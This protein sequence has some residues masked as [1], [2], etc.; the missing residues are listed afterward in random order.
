[1]DL[2]LS[3]FN[4][5]EEKMG[6]IAL[7]IERL[8]EGELPDLSNVIFD[9]IVYTNGNISYDSKTGV[10]TFN[11][12]GRYII[13]WCVITQ[14]SSTDVAVFSLNSSQGDELKGNSPTIPGEV[15]GFGIINT[16]SA[17]VNVSLVNSSAALINYA[18]NVPVK[19]TLTVV[20]DT[21]PIVG[22]P[23]PQGIQGPTGPQGIQ[24]P[25]GPQGIQGPIGP[26]GSLGNTS[27]CFS[28]AQLSNTLTQLI[29]LYPTDTWTV[30]TPS[31]YSVSGVP[32]HLYTSPDGNAPGLL[33]LYDGTQ[34]ESIPL[35]A[36]TAVYVGEG[37][38]YDNSI[39]YLPP[40]SVLPEGCDTDLITA[41]QSYLPIL[42]EVVILL[43]PTVQVSGLV[44]KN[45]YGMLVTSD[46]DGN[47]PV[48]I[49]TS[50]I[51]TI[52]TDVTRST[53]RSI[54]KTKVSVK[55]TKGK[56]L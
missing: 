28:I 1:M 20:Q 37:T 40:P 19:A 24:G 2:Q 35:L 38:V 56:K 18:D 33:V 10:I 14:T 53:M 50:K 25:S 21:V 26:Q 51:E 8:A 7:Q 45:E 11:E 30:Y 15:V 9:T 4:I 55:N 44:Y 17:P 6:N 23:G 22:P 13:N 3:N 34:Y 12:Q 27:Y 46:T 48:F 36:I 49:V 5:W 39:N 31:L 47:T 43:G 54:N 52:L 29:N 41:V 16:T 32:D 42:T